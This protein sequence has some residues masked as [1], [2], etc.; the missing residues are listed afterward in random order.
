ML[1]TSSWAL[2]SLRR[3]AQSARSQC[4]TGELLRRSRNAVARS[5]H[6]LTSTILG[7][8]LGRHLLRITDER[9]KRALVVYKGGRSARAKQRAAKNRAA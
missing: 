1:K 8:L 6:L 5:R 2:D 9:R 4:A 7:K 3:V